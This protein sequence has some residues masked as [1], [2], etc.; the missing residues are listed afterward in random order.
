MPGKGRRPVSQ[1]ESKRRQAEGA[2]LQKLREDARVTQEEAAKA[3]GILSNQLS[4]KERG[5]AP[6]TAAEVSTLERFYRTM[7][8]IAEAVGANED[9]S[10]SSRSSSETNLPPSGR[11]GETGA[12]GANREA[13]RQTPGYWLA[14]QEIA[15][16]D[17]RDVAELQIQIASIQDHLNKMQLRAAEQLARA[18][19]ALRDL[20][21][22]TIPV[23]V[24]SRTDL[25]PEQLERLAQT[26][27]ALAAVEKATRGKGAGD[28]GAGEPQGPPESG[29]RRRRAGGSGG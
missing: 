11:E 8:I 14:T 17:I 26:Q 3:L 22:H 6:F 10:S 13:L 19:A 16:D 18:N 4:R 2:R 24:T 1:A 15:A 23:P 28:A 27:A 7:G 9:E 5:R 20:V 12:G 29:R 25:T 21:Q